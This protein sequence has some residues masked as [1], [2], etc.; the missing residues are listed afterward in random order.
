MAK[1]VKQ[2]AF[3]GKVKSDVGRQKNAASSYGYLILPKGVQVYSPTPGSK[4]S[5]DVIPYTITDNHHPDRNAEV[6]VAEKG[7]LWYKRPFKTHRSIGTDNDS[8]VCLSSFG[9]KCPICEY[10]KKLIKEGADEALIKELKPSNRNLYYVIPRGIKKLE[11]VVH[12]F[13]FS[14]WNFQNLLNEEI[15]ENEENEVFPDLEEGKTLKVRW[16]EETFMK[17]TYAKASRID[18]VDREEAIDADI[19]GD[20]PS[21][22]D[23]LQELSYEAMFAKFHEI[24]EG[25]LVEEEDDEDETP[26]K[27]ATPTKKPTKKLPT[28]DWDDISE[29]DITELIDVVEAHGLEVDVDDFEEAYDLQVAIAEALDIEVPKKKAALAK[30]P[31]KKAVVEEDDDEEDEPALKKKVEVKEES[32]KKAKTNKCPAGGTFGKDNDELE[33]CD[34]CPL[35][36]ACLDAN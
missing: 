31:T 5:F 24:D 21:L 16:D 35:W 7:D 15:E 14:Q 19:L 36:D 30:K 6:G 2:S 27:K 33:E 8:V 25:E 23:V 20:L 18:F 32:A 3:R 22:D 1:K 29:M 13:D 9:K 17:N 34:G 28:L 26:K 11:E 12:L 10:R 4:E